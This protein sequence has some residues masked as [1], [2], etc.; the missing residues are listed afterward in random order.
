MPNRGGKPVQLSRGTSLLGML[1]GKDFLGDASKWIKWI[2]I[3]MT[4]NNGQYDYEILN[5]NYVL[6]IFVF[7][8]NQIYDTKQMLRMISTMYSRLY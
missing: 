7:N 1:G 5:M 6:G 2:E 3:N 4:C 8:S